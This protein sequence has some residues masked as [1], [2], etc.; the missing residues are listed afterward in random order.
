VV[1]VEVHVRIRLGRPHHRH[2]ELDAEVV[3]QGPS[4]WGHERYWLNEQQRN[5]AR[6]LRISNAEK[7]YRLPLNVMEGNYKLARDVCPWWDA[8]A[9]ARKTG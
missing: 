2:R 3:T 4:L 7:G 6:E 1:A 5:E 8:T 9:P